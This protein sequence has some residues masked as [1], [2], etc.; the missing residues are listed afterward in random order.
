MVV[1]VGGNDQFDGMGEKTR[2]EDSPFFL[3]FMT[4]S[5]GMPSSLPVSVC[6]N[7]N[8]VH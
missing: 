8:D 6:R 4:V 3:F 1:V 5:I 2:S 7:N